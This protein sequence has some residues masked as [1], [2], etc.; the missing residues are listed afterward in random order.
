[1]KKLIY[2][3]PLG[4]IFLNSCGEDKAAVT[5]KELI[6]EKTPITDTATQQAE[7]VIEPNPELEKLLKKFNVAELPYAIDDK[8]LDKIEGGKELKGKDIKLLAQ[9]IP[10]KDL[11][12]DLDYALKNFYV[13]DSVKAKGTY[14]EWANGLDLGQTKQS[15]A[16]SLA[17][18]KTGE[19][20]SVLF[21]ILE[22]STVEACPYSWAKTV[23]ATTIN[24]NK[25]GETIIFAEHSGGGDA[26]VS[27]DRIIK[28]IVTPE[29]NFTLV[30]KE[31]LDQDEPKI[32][33]TDGCYET[34]LKDGKFIFTK[35][36]KKAPR[37]VKKKK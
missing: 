29:L 31:E 19:N 20:S 16:Y 32:E 27:F 37:K 2:I 1:M 22:H 15:K 25:I 17:Q 21:W 18:I 5:N 33:I 14:E 26:P 12:M 28:G 30:L 8:K 34:E 10:E 3:L 7:E 4:F 9:T 36:E 13:I 24:K 6:V 35:E 11:F 23:L